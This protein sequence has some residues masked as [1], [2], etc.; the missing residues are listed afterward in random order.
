[1]RLL[2][3]PEGY[4]LLSISSAHCS[5]LVELP[6]HHRDPFDRMLVA[7]AQSEGLPLLTRDRRLMAY[8]EEAEI[9][10]FP[11]D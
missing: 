8:A 1:M 5:T 2:G 10:R 7:Q 6:R 9:L 11:A 4:L 3:I